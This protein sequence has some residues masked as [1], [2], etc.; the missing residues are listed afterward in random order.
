MMD[1]RKLQII[2]FTLASVS[3]VLASTKLLIPC[4]DNPFQNNFCITDSNQPKE[5][6]KLRLISW[7]N[8][9]NNDSIRS[10]IFNEFIK[11]RSST[12]NFKLLRLPLVLLLDFL[13]VQ[14]KSNSYQYTSDTTLFVFVR[15]LPRIGIEPVGNYYQ[16]VY[17]LSME[18]KLECVISE[19]MTF[20]YSINS[21][22][23]ILEAYEGDDLVQVLFFVTEEDFLQR[24]SFIQNIT[25][26]YSYEMNNFMLETI[27]SDPSETLTSDRPTRSL[28]LCFS[29]EDQATANLLNFLTVAIFNI[30][31]A[32]FL[33][34]CFRFYRRSSS[35]G[36]VDCDAQK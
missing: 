28:A 23:H 30:S 6:Y 29:R 27:S 7:F 20:Q 8:P 13:L 12:F 11:A 10:E 18:D 32:L 34:I 36:V 35:V 33:F 17:L 16:S 9:K 21:Q 5:S 15:G 19:Q 3:S 24:E 31:F 14:T 25:M 22:I 2:I 4:H 1:V 26:G